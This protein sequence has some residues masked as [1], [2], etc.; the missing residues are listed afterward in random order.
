MDAWGRG[1]TLPTDVDLAHCQSRWPMGTTLQTRQPKRRRTGAWIRETRQRR[2]RGIEPSKRFPDTPCTSKTVLESPNRRMNPPPP[3]P[4][5]EPTQQRCACLHVCS[6]LGS[7]SRLKAMRLLKSGGVSAVACEV[8]FVINRFPKAGSGH[9]PCVH[10]PHHHQTTND[11]PR[12]TCSFNV[13]TKL[14]E[15]IPPFI[16]SSTPSVTEMSSN[17]R[18]STQPLRLTAA[19][20]EENDKLFRQFTRAPE[21]LAKR[22]GS[23]GSQGTRA[24]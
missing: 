1:A 5:D 17:A 12:E 10:H 22:W 21:Q 19:Q 11:S 3:H 4:N 16:P 18:T 7:S 24:V 23:G 13:F 6:V 2:C 20:L 14:S 9:L 8:L 15:L